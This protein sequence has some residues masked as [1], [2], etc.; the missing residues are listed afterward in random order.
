LR[1]SSVNFRYRVYD[2]PAERC[3]I[4]FIVKTKLG[5][6]AKR[7]KIKRLLREVYRTHQHYLSDLFDRQEIGFHGVFMARHGNVSVE[8]LEADMVPILQ[9]MRG[10]LINHIDAAKPVKDSH[11]DK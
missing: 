10:I 2:D 9:K 3:L 11:K 7:N 4:G 5:K 6:A 1:S 8:S